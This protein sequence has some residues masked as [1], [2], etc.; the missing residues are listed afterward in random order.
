M[1]SLATVKAHIMKFNI[2][3]HLSGPSP[4]ANIN[5]RLLT[6]LKC[7]LKAFWKMEHA[8]FSKIFSKVFKTLLKLF[9]FFSMSKNRK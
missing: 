9:E 1:S 7:H 5:Q 6:P 2:M 4:F 8:P 3:H